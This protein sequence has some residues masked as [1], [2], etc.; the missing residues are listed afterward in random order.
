MPPQVKRTD[1]G[2]GPLIELEEVSEETPVG[3]AGE[4]IPTGE[5]DDA[6]L[7]FVGEEIPEDKWTQDE[8]GNIIIPAESESENFVGEELTLEGAPKYKD[9][10]YTLEGFKEWEQ[11]EKEEG[12]DGFWHWA[13]K[14]LPEASKEA[15]KI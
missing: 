7:N 3:L 5:V 14:T 4:T 11:Q 12:R 10:I 13:T 6:S 1:A 15:L 2:T 9:G 8:D